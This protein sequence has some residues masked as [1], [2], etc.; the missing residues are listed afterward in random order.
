MDFIFTI[1]D[2]RNGLE[3]LRVGIANCE[4]NKVTIRRLRTQL[5]FQTSSFPDAVNLTPDS[6]PL[7]RSME[8]TFVVAISFVIRFSQNNKP[9]FHITR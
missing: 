5:E 3:C 8:N 2:V 7:W 4:M 1:W 9:G 6:G